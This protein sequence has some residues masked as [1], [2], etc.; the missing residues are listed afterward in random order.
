MN[1]NGWIDTL[2]RATY[3]PLAAL[4]AVLAI[5]V[6]GPRVVQ[7]DNWE[8][9]WQ[10]GPMVMS[11]SCYRD[12]DVGGAPI[13]LETR[14]CLKEDCVR[15]KLRVGKELRVSGCEDGDLEQLIELLASSG[16][17]YWNARPGGERAVECK[18]AKSQGV[19]V[20]PVTR[21]GTFVYKNDAENLQSLIE[22]IRISALKKD[23][24]LAA[25]LTQALFPNADRIRR[26]L[27]D[28]TPQ[29]IVDSIGNMYKKWTP[30]PDDTIA[31]AT[32]LVADPK[33]SEIAVYGA[34]TEQIAAQEGGAAYH[35]PGGA[36]R[37]AK[38]ILK[39][40]MTFFEVKLVEPGKRWGVRYHLF[41][42]DGDR[43]C[44]LGPAWRIKRRSNR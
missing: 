21:G 5:V 19:M 9:A 1:E 39:P 29:K 43:W 14:V 4:L 26:A 18:K 44:M 2:R 30:S 6:V 8:E 33:K 3:P 24:K 40:G 41:F 13:T 11:L 27:K 25:T 7:A 20:A 31:W 42:W 12:T 23:Y 16:I 17:Q 36:I 22:T 34:T 15:W 38:T 37:L 32:L 35:F 28:D 10:C